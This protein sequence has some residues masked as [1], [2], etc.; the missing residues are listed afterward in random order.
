MDKSIEYKRYKTVGSSVFT[1]LLCSLAEGDIFS[2]KNSMRD[3]IYIVI[4]LKYS[5]FDINFE[6]EWQEPVPIYTLRNMSTGD[7]YE[8]II[9]KLPDAEITLLG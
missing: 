5:T 3:S 6:Q 9:T 1:E 4:G 7:V 2:V 8:G